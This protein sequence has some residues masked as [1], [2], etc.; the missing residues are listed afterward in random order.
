MR[1]VSKSSS[2]SGFTII[3]VL[4]SAVVFMIGF[5]TLVSLLNSTML[6][7]S[8]K[9]LLAGSCAAQRTMLAA[10]SSGDTTS[11][12]TVTENSGLK[13]RIV[14]S[15]VVTDR[16]VKVRVTA[17]RLKKSKEVIELYDEFVMPQR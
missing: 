14:K 11:C 6:N 1:A 3:E 5:T 13:F 7:F 15:A 8:T 16:L 4:I 10:V 9:E 17:S 12:D 2:Q